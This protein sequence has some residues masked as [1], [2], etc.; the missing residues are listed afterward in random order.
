VEVEKPTVSVAKKWYVWVPLGVVVAG[1]A[2]GGGLGWF[3]SQP[4]PPTNV[5][6][7]VQALTY[8]AT[9]RGW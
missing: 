6:I 4:T 9:G 3:Y 7:V 1:A 5:P 8:P 2:I